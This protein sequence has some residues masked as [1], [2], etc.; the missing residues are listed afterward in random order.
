MAATS[1][2]LVTARWFRF[3]SLRSTELS[4]RTIKV[5]RYA[6]DDTG[7]ASPVLL[8]E[9]LELLHVVVGF[10]RRL[11]L[12]GAQGQHA[13][14]RLGTDE[15]QQFQKIGAGEGDAAPGRAHVVARD[16][17]EDR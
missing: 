3:V 5:P 7:R 4:S 13:Q 8:V 2:E 9:V 1:L 12:G 6:R 15:R 10:R 14:P 11:L 16:V 17:E